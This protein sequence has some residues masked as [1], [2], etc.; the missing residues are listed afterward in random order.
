MAKWDEME[1]P[2]AKTLL[3]QLSAKPS[4]RELAEQRELAFITYQLEMGA[5][6]AD[7]DHLDR[8]QR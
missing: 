7:R 6:T 2:K 4:I 1:A 5:Y 8:A 3:E